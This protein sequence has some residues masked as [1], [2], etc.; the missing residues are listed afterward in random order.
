MFLIDIETMSLDEKDT[1]ETKKNIKNENMC[2]ERYFIKRDVGE[3]GSKFSMKQTCAYCPETI[4][5]EKKTDK[6]VYTFSSSDGKIDPYFANKAYSELSE[7]RKDDLLM[8]GKLLNN[9]WTKDKSDEIKKHFFDKN[10]IFSKSDIYTEEEKKNKKDNLPQSGTAWKVKQQE[11]D[12]DM[13]SGLQG[14][15]GVM[16]PECNT[17]Q[18]EVL[19][20]YNTGNE[21]T[22]KDIRKETRGVLGD[23]TI[24]GEPAWRQTIPKDIRG[25]RYHGGDNFKQCVYGKLRIRDGDNKHT[26][27]TDEEE[28]KELIDEK[29]NLLMNAPYHKIHSCLEDTDVHKDCRNGYSDILLSLMGTDTSEGPP[30]T[31]TPLSETQF[32][33]RLARRQLVHLAGRMEYNDCGYVSNDT[34]AEKDKYDNPMYNVSFNVNIIDTIMGFIGK[35]VGQSDY[36]IG[37]FNLIE[38][39][40]RLATFF[41]LALILYMFTQLLLK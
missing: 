6:D 19:N 15:G 11:Y 39:G 10:K 22:K 41:V 4:T 5:K 18:R 16:G 36:E 7:E 3:Q 14:K 28:K 9:I 23:C 37:E 24:N 30:G 34:E 38:S 12:I 25:S 40:M 29:L 17:E 27:V 13:T 33:D 8:C 2:G 31:D 26:N 21:E 1:A 20:K 35:L 32:K